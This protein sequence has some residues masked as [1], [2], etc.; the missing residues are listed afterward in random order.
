MFTKCFGWQI[1]AKERVLKAQ[2]GVRKRVVTELLETEKNYVK[3]IEI[4]DNQLIQPLKLAMKKGKPILKNDEMHACF[5]NL[6]QLLSEHKSLLD[7]FQ[8]RI[9]DNWDDDSTIGDIFLRKVPPS[10]FSSISFLEF[11]FFFSLFFQFL[12]FYLDNFFCF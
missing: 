5:A 2:N 4:V 11:F 10:P 1:K 6:S 8:P 12:N 7:L 9:V 3:S